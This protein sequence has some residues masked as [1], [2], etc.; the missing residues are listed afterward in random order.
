MKRK[1]ELELPPKKSELGGCIS[2]KKEIWRQDIG[3]RVPLSIDRNELSNLNN[4]CRWL[5][6]KGAPNVAKAITTKMYL[7]QKG[8]TVV[9]IRP[10]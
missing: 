7:Q 2:S 5:D 4:L 10:V 6:V 3:Y 1:Y 8:A 9:T